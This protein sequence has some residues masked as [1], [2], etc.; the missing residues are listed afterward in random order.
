MEANAAAAAALGLHIHPKRIAMHKR[1]QNAQII[2]VFTGVISTPAATFL[3]THIPNPKARGAVVKKIRMAFLA[4]TYEAWIANKTH[5]NNNALPKARTY[6]RRRAWRS[7]PRSD[8]R[9]KRQRIHPADEAA[10]L[11]QPLDETV[12]TAFVTLHPTLASIL[13]LYRTPEM[14]LRLQAGIKGDN[15]EARKKA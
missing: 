9:R 13:P 4:F 3:R 10:W 7:M 11:I 2:A 12:W 6:L 1:E 14:L 5:L 8:Q 15:V